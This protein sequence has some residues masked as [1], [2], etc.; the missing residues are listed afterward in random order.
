MSALFRKEAFAQARPAAYGT[1]MLARPVSHLVLTLVFAAFALALV[2]FF[3]ATS[4]TRKAKVPGVLLPDK[5]LIRVMPAQPG[6][7]SERHVHEGQAVKAGDVL[8]VLVSE[9]SGAS[10]GVA[11]A[12]LATLLR[13]RRDSFVAEREQIR[14]QVRQRIDAAHR[15]SSDLEAERGRIAHQVV[16]QQRRVEL[17]DNVLR[18][19][20]ELGAQHFVSAV[21]VQDKQGELLDQQQKLADLQ[22]AQAA[23]GRDLAALQDEVRDLQVQAQRDRQAEDRNIGDTERD[24][25]END[26][27]RVIQVRAPQDGTVSAITADV[28][29]SIGAQQGIASILPAG[30]VLEAELYAPSRAAGFVHPG[31]PVML[32]YQSYAFQKFGQTRGI[33]REVSSMAMRP[34]EMALPG[35]ATGVAAAGAADSEPLY[36][37]RVTLPSQSVTAFGH[38]HALKPGTA[39]EG[40]LLL[41]TR[42]IHEFVLEPL[43]TIK[44][45]L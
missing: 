44:G 25:T 10:S 38:D 27:R 8:F 24:L 5:G 2:A 32:R 19:T 7:V 39:L 18:R 23:V 30:S 34:D 31:M 26:A 20:T 3:A 12:R 11:E 16:L 35:A 15:K 4:Y 42:R 41:E 45:G 40:S 36:R 37:V 9:R 43:Y 17:A 28:G 14:L 22:R 6:V 1:V 29:Q 33:V 21:Q 13:H